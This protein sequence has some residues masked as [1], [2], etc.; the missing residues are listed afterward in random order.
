[1]RRTTHEQVAL[2]QEMNDLPQFRRDTY[3]T[4]F[5]EGWG[6]YAEYLGIE[7]G[8]YTPRMMDWIEAREGAPEVR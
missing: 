7:M 2:T 8:I 1:M 6:L 4:A 3:I 5:G